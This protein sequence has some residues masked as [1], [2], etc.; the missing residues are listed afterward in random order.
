MLEIISVS[1]VPITIL[2]L[3]SSII[4]DITY[5]KTI[6]DLLNRL[7]AK[8]LGEYNMVVNAEGLPKG[9]N[10]LKKLSKENEYKGFYE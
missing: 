2:V 8:N 3:V 4:K 6:N 9:N 7:M 1:L 10:H 5:K